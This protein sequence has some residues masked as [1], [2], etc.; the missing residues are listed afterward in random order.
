[1]KVDLEALKPNP[2][3]DF[4]IDPLDEERIADLTRSIG[5]DGFWG[6][7]AC[8]RLPDGTIQIGTGH[9]R[10]QAAI[11]AGIKTADLFVKQATSDAEMVIIFYA[12]ENATQRGNSGSAQIGSVAS[13]IRFLA[14][15]ILM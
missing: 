10:V 4:E 6:C 11:R 15:A 8:R 1:M 2:M 14:K 13:A 9:H 7:I 12:R 3:R 5:E